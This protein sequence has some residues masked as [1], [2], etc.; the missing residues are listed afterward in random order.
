ME[1]QLQNPQDSRKKSFN[2]RKGFVK[3]AKFVHP[4]ECEVEP[5]KHS[6]CIVYG[7]SKISHSGVTCW[8][9]F[10]GYPRKMS[11]SSLANLLNQLQSDY[12]STRCKTETRVTRKLNAKQ[13][14]QIKS[15]A[16]KLCY[17]SRVRTFSSK[18][19]GEYRFKVAFITLTAPSTA[20]D[21]QII[22]AFPAFLE[23]LHRTVGCNYVWKKELGEQN[24][25]LHFHILLFQGVKWSTNEQKKDTNSHTRIELPRSRKL[26]AH[27][28]SKYMSK[29]FE[30]PKEY[31]YIHGHSEIL[32]T[33]EDQKFIEN[34]LPKDEILELMKYFRTI[35][36]TFLTH[37]CVD[38]RTIQQIAPT[39]HYYFMKQFT[40]FQEKI[41]LPQ[42]Y[43]YV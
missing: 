31:G 8:K 30:M 23:W 37:I 9:N 14:R 25:G 38:L 1:L 18:K 6:S 26:V 34:D 42:K 5:I 43:W 39:I 36:D 35:K 29:A 3:K 17:Y 21:N 33:L 11:K 20:T 2:V 16:N 19:S 40:D 7:M 27:Y 10:E 15:Y 22:K 32:E 4:F 24:G 12:D 13:T 28:I 41:C